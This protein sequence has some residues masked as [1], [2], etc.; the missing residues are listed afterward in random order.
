MDFA[1]IVGRA[2]SVASGTG[3]VGSAGFEDS[4]SSDDLED[5]EATTSLSAAVTL[6]LAS[7]VLADT[8]VALVSGSLA[9][10]GSLATTGLGAGDGLVALLPFETGDAGG[11]GTA[12]VCGGSG[13]DSCLGTSLEGEEIDLGFA[14][15]FLGLEAA[16]GLFSEAATNSVSFSERVSANLTVGVALALLGGCGLSPF[17]AFTVAPSSASFLRALFAGSIEAE[18]SCS[19][20]FGASGSALSLCFFGAEESL[21]RLLSDLL[22]ESEGAAA[23]PTAFFAGTD[24]FVGLPGLVICPERAFFIVI[25]SDTSRGDSGVANFVK[26]VS[27]SKNRR[28]GK[29]ARQRLRFAPD[30][31]SSRAPH[32]GLRLAKAQLRGVYS[33]RH[34]MKEQAHNSRADKKSAGVLFVVDDEPMLLE[35]ASVILVPLGYEVKTFRDPAAALQAYTD[36]TLRPDILITDYA[37]HTLNGM[38]LLRACRRQRPSQKVL[39][40]SGTVDETIYQQSP[41]KPDRFLAKPYQARQLVEAVQALLK[42]KGSS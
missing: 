31:F 16:A 23:A 37:M 32:F 40:V 21:L 1:R 19:T 9:A 13:C 10:T 12:G 11:C 15:A 17:T 24:F 18:T 38:D 4:G 6:G 36:A 35:L 14:G 26:T 8:V 20:D 7:L 29:L 25:S 28:N 39:M 34:R 2:F 22:P 3:C 5:A 27:G 42:Q 30:A 41:E 33:Q